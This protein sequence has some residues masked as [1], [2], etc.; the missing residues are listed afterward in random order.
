[1]SHPQVPCI[2]ITPSHLT[3]SP[4][5]HLH[6]LS[7]LFSYTPPQTI[8]P[9]PSGPLLIYHTK[10]SHPHTRD[11]AISILSHPPDPQFR[12][13]HNCL[14]LFNI[15]FFFINFHTSFFY[16]LLSS[17]QHLILSNAA[18]TTPF[19]Y[20]FF[21]F[22]PPS[23]LSHIPLL[24]CQT[25]P[26]SSASKFAIHYCL[27]SILLSNFQNTKYHSMYRDSL[28]FSLFYYATPATA[29]SV[30][31]IKKQFSYTNVLTAIEDKESSIPMKEE[32][33]K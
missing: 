10:P 27:H 33:N 28:S 23:S 19:H 13:F 22:F 31:I 18:F 26:L 6:W 14:K 15:Y 25:L 20:I 29:G 1:M 30:H 2:E 5:S 8:S 4:R 24:H 17:S 11:Q 9:S 7:E 16:N 3:P 12:F 32:I 21:G